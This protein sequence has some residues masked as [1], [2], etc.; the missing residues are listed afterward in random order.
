MVYIL[1]N[2]NIMLKR[3]Q[4]YLLSFF[5]II[6]SIIY[7]V[8]GGKGNNRGNLVQTPRNMSGMSSMM[9]PANNNYK[10]GQYTGTSADAY[11]GNIQVKTIVQNGKI[12]DVQFLDYPQDRQT[13]RMINQDAMPV[14]K[15]EAI[16]AQSA[17]VQIVSGA[18][19]TSQAF[20]QSLNSALTQA[21][22]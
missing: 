19:D 13:S 6:S 20:Q 8:L 11:Y 16:T 9:M 5:V 4:K 14:L 10:D 7:V 21:I 17:N 2:N 15:Q 22:N 12:T 1:V 18:T 3:T